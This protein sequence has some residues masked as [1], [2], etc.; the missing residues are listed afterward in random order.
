M[1]TVKG[2]AIQ[3]TLDGHFDV[4]IHGCNCQ[5]LMGA[6][7]AAGVSKYLPQA[8][9]ADKED[10]ARYQKPEDK[11]G[12][13]SSAVIGRQDNTAFLVINAYTQLYPGSGSLSYTAI[14]EVFRTLKA[15]LGVEARKAQSQAPVRFAYPM[16]GAGIAGGDWSI[17]SK[18]I[19]EELDGEDHTFVEYMP[20]R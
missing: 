10:D 15:Q 19:A 6:G 7:F 13:F 16:L 3:L 4:L 12:K 9:R 14:R 18:I 5:V 20:S 11:L 1:K 17:I 2:D 8:E